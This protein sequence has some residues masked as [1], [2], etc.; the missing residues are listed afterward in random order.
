MNMELWGSFQIFVFLNR[1][2]CISC[3]IV[4]AFAYVMFE[5]DEHF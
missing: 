3:K 1:E 4:P 2:F 5:F